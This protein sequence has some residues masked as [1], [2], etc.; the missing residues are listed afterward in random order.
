MAALGT[1]RRH[2]PHLEGVVMVAAARYGGWYDGNGLVFVGG[3]PPRL[4]QGEHSNAAATYAGGGPHSSQITPAQAFD[5]ALSHVQYPTVTLGD[6][7]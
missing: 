7:P 1:G 4:S 5:S 6:F 3:R 2:L